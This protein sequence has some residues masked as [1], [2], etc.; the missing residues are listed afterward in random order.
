MQIKTLSSSATFILKFVMPFI[1]VVAF[2]YS[3]FEIRTPASHDMGWLHLIASGGALLYVR[4]Y[5]GL[6]RV[7]C[8]ANNLFISNYF[9]EI[10]VPI[11]SIKSVCDNMGYIFSYAVIV[12]FK[13]ATVFG[14]KIKFRPKI[15][16]AMIIEFPMNAYWFSALFQQQF[17]HPIIGE[18]QE[19][20]GLR[21]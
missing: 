9:Q 17:E 14:N 8:D 18:L 12:D 3:V 7:R 1:F 11:N 13:E 2:I 16:L 20:A 21:G 10:S 19:L 4:G 6:K 5:F 15:S